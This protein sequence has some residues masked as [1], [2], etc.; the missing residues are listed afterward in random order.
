M[1]PDN[2]SVDWADEAQVTE[3]DELDVARGQKT[4]PVSVE[5][6]S[7]ESEKEQ[8]DEWDE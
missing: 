6:C 7:Y 2:L 8:R 5:K 4:E 1:V 3:L